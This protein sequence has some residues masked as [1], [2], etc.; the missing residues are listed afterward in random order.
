MT[1]WRKSK[2]MSEHDE[3]GRYSMILEW[4]PEGSIYVVTVPELRGGRTHGATLQEAVPQ[5][6]D[7][8]ETWVDAMRHWSRPIP[9]PT[10]FDLDGPDPDSWNSRL[11]EQPD[12]GNA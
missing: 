3:Y 1:R 4:E 2:Q 10:Y 9:P 11:T 8:I 6:Q 5:G 12:A 7:A